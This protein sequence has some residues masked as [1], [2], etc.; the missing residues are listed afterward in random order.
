MNSIM[1]STH[2]FLLVIA[3]SITSCITNGQTL[4]PKPYPAGMKALYD[5]IV[6]LDS[7]LFTS[8]NTCDLVTYAGLFSEDFE[9]YH[10]QGGIMTDK[11]AS[12]EA[13]KKNVCGKVRRELLKGSIEVS[14]IAN[15]G[16]VAI[17]M[18]RF[19]NNREK[20]PAEHRYARFVI[21]WKRE[22]TDWKITRVISLH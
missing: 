8:Y 1:K 15:Y 20:P 18:H 9:F 14:P 5:T 22:K 11:A 4:L 21:I 2:V 12:I 19:H 13:F 7:I 10:D 16:A 3:F 6:R 17:G